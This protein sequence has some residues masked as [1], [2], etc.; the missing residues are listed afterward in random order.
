MSLKDFVP[1]RTPQNVELNN[2]GVDKESVGKGR[3]QMMLDEGHQIPKSDQHHDIDV[4]IHGVVIGVVG[5]SI[6]YLGSY[7]D[8]IEDD[9]G[10]LDSDEQESED[11]TIP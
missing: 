9:D 10:D 7:K 5:I 2:D 11:F 1:E 8:A 4:L 3:P 6:V